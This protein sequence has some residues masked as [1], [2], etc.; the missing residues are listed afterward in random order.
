MD[1]AFP[2]LVHEM[3]PI[4]QETQ[5]RN[6]GHANEQRSNETKKNIAIH[7]FPSPRNF[8]GRAPRTLSTRDII[9]KTGII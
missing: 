6:Q 1:F 4:S 9:K 2:W 8:R 7:R 5:G 3:E